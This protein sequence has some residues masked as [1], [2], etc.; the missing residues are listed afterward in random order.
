MLEPLYILIKKNIFV[1]S[2]VVVIVAY[3]GSTILSVVLSSAVSSN[4]KISI[5]NKWFVGLLII[6]I[7]IIIFI[8]T[9]YYYI[10]KVEGDKGATGHIGFDGQP[11]YE[12]LIPISNTC[13][14]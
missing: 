4:N 13:K 11:G 1:I 8:C 9:F 10:I 2:L 5:G 14:K 12:C 7:T 3:F 6:N